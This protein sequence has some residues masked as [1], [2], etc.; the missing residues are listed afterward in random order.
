MNNYR[1]D[2]IPWCAL[3]L[4]ACG[5]GSSGGPS[6]TNPGASSSPV[7]PASS[8][9]TLSS[10]VTDASSSIAVSVVSLSSV[11]T[12]SAA[13][14]QVPAGNPGL[15][16]A[17]GSLHQPH[18]IAAP[19]KIIDVVAR[20]VELGHNIDLTDSASDDQ[21]AIEAVL[22]DAQTTAGAQV[23]FP[24]G[25]YNIRSISLPKSDLQLQGQSRDETI[26]KSN[27]HNEG[28]S[29]NIYGKNNIKIKSITFT[30]TWSG[31]YSTDTNVNNPEVGGPKYAIAT[32]GNSYNITLDD[33]LLEKFSRMGVRIAA[34][35]HDVIV[36]NSLA[37]NATDVAGGGAGYGFVI[38]GPTHNNAAKN[39]YLGDPLQDTYFNILENNTSDSPYIRHAVIVQYWAHNNLIT[40]NHFDE[41]RLD[42]IDLHGEDEYANEISHNRVTNSQRAGIAL[43]NSGAGHDKTGIENWIHHNTIE[44]SAWGITVQFGTAY[45][46][47]ENNTIRENNSLTHAPICA[48]RLGSS[49]HSVLRNNQI[50]ENL[51]AGHLGICLTDD[52]AEGEEPKGGP[53]NWVISGNRIINSGQEIKNSSTLAAD[54]SI[55]TTW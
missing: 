31:N 41:T 30:S 6:A 54:N 12:S 39:P 52:N 16:N 25:T 3:G 14:V 45:S 32:S 38:Q 9:Q 23:Y 35:S 40:G 43:G 34:G 46:T 21:L 8:A 33:L 28:T 17:D 47:I 5:G 20:A 55:Q 18:S 27:L 42:A 13:T 19:T 48:I 7:V 44:R 15:R 24:E 37:R 22:K 11:A 2:L 53:S 49:S 36:R 10:V 26:F 29:L 1:G 4:V 50:V 51:V